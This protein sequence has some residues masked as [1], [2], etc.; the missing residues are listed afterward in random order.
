MSNRDKK[1]AHVVIGDILIELMR[2]RQSDRSLHGRH[3]SSMKVEAL[4]DVL[5]RMSMQPEHAHETSRR[6]DMIAQSA[7]DADDH[8]YKKFQSASLEVRW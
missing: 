1:P 3:D 6:L 8:L 2:L 4:L 5:T 7:R